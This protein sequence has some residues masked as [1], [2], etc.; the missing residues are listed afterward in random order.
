MTVI[1]KYLPLISPVLV[2]FGWLIINLQNNHGE[3]RKEVRDNLNTIYSDIEDLLEKSVAFHSDHWN[4]INAKLITAKI[5]RIISSINTISTVI[6]IDS[7]SECKSLRQSITLN[8]F[9]KSTH[10][11]LSGEEEQITEITDATYVILDKLES[12]FIRKYLSPEHKMQVF[13]VSF[14][15]F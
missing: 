11:R 13:C 9:D 12:S 7:S 15:S 14:H 6:G 4:D 3:T 2:I 10:K 1:L 5:D 8:N